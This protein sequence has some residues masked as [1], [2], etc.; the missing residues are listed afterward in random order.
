MFQG[1]NNADLNGFDLRRNLTPAYDLVGA[2]ATDVFTDEAVE[3]IRRHDTRIP[4]F[5]YLS[6]LAVHAA[7]RG[8]FLEAPQEVINRFQHIAD[9]NRRT[10]AGN[11]ESGPLKI[12]AQAQAQVKLTPGV[13]SQKLTRAPSP[14]K[15]F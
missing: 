11:Y 4:L 8:K 9:P 3:T 6:H 7:N 12:L 5:M 10:F 13:R 1:N 2:Y 14:I 15:D